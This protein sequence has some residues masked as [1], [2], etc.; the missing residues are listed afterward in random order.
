[1]TEYAATRECLGEI[2]ICIND[3]KKH[4]LTRK[5]PEDGIDLLCDQF[6]SHWQLSFITSA[7]KDMYAHVLIPSL[8]PCTT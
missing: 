8:S 6:C 4:Q 7:R 3:T 2:Y 1:M 5:F